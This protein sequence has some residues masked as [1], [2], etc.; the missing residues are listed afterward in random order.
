MRER[1][2]VLIVDDEASVRKVL[3]ALLEQAGYRTTR[4]ATGEEALDLVRAQDPDIVVTDLKMPGMDGLELLSR[5]REAFPEIPVVLL[6]AHGTVETAVEAMK[7]GAHDFLTKPF[8]KTSVL[9]VIGKALGQAE[10]SRQ[11]FQ[12][13]L[14]EGQPCGIPGG[15]RAVEELRR[16]VERVA[17]SPATVLIT[18]ETGTG[19][20]LVAAALHQMSPRRDA[21]FVKINCGAM[22]ET[23][24]EAELFGYERGAFTGA[25]RT[26][27]GRFELAH[28]GTLFLDEIGELPAATQVKML[29]VLQDGVVDRVGGSAPVRVDV[30]LIAATNRDLDAEVSSGR[31]R[32]DLLYRL[33]VVEIRV[34]PLG[35]RREDIPMLVDLF[36]DKHASRLGRPRPRVT[37]ESVQALVNR[38]WPGNVRELENLVERALLLGEGPALEPADFGAEPAPAAPSGETDV[39]RAARAAASAAERRLIRAALEATGGNVSEAARKV[40]LSRRGLQL[41]MKELGLRSES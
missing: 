30:R 11:E 37:G 20:E 34:P 7:R 26:K 29:R 21:P 16:L 32:Q 1:P 24:V 39:K 33:R 23:L 18:G 10:R 27:P 12:G 40:G 41:K 5:V 3:G 31:F 38:D 14:V 2:H 25:E 9:E 36:L 13:P 22:P 19:K 17:P 35:E 15:S 8:E 4:A 6:S 28:T